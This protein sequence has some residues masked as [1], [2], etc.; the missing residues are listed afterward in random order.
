MTSASPAPAAGSPQRLVAGVS[1]PS[2][3]QLAIALAGA[4]VLPQTPAFCRRR[5]TIDDLIR[6]ATGKVLDQIHIPHAAVTRWH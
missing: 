1:G 2:A 5:R 4:T 3:P 6:P